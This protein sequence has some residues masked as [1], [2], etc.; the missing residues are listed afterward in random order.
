VIIFTFWTLCLQGISP[1][2]ALDVRMGGTQS[3]SADGDKEKV[4]S[5]TR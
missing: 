3:S 1:Q 4:Y 2:Y 5:G